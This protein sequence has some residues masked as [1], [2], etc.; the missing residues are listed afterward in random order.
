MNSLGPRL[1]LSRLSL[2]DVALFLDF[3]G[4]L[5]PLQSRPTDVIPDAERTS[6]LVRTGQALAGRVALISGR[7]VEDID[8]L[9]EKSCM[10]VAGVH[11]LQH[12]SPSGR[13]EATEA[14]P[15]IDAATEILAELAR[16]REGVDLEHKGQAV[17]L[18]YRGA[19]GAEAALVECVERLARHEALVVQRGDKV[20]ELKSPGPDKGAAVQR[21]LTELPFRDHIPIYIGD[22]FTDEAGFVAAAAA[23]GFGIVVGDRRPTA[24]ALTLPDP[25][26]VRAWISDALGRG[27]FDLEALQWVD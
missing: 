24:A 21:F 27:A 16:S 7:T 4:T 13:M 14:H 1:T 5:T 20:I 25:V 9:V 11:G 10:S 22:D 3:D 23:G 19:P 12:R 18:H 26:A 15:R 8:A 2:D 17:A 6:L